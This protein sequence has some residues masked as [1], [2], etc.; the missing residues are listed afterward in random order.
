MTQHWPPEQPTRPSS[1][2]AMA[3]LLVEVREL[4]STQ[5]RILDAQT[6]LQRADARIL[7]AQAGQAKTLLHMSEQLT[8]LYEAVLVG[9][10]GIDG[11]RHSMASRM[12]ELEL[13]DRLYHGSIRPPPRQWKSVL[14]I[15][16][17]LATMFGAGAGLAALF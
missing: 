15:G 13:K 4:R 8:P 9:A 5:V 17:A 10:V 2:D 3:Q 16:I 12:D 11:K 7:A 6:E 1:P 14:A